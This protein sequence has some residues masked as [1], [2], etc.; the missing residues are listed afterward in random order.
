MKV[1][2]NWK[3]K[4]NDT[5]LRSLAEHCLRHVRALY[6]TTLEGIVDKFYWPQIEVLADARQVDPWT[7]RST[8]G[9]PRLNCI[10][11]PGR[12]TKKF[13]TSPPYC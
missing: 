10:A 2:I 9:P 6:P 8:R 3:P 1:N 12:I 7:A 5:A 11:A 4:V 13:F